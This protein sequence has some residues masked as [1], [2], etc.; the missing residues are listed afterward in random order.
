MRAPLPAGGKIELG[1]GYAGALAPKASPRRRL[2]RASRGGG[3]GWG[4]ASRQQQPTSIPRTSHHFATASAAK[5]KKQK[6]RQSAWQARGE[7]SELEVSGRA[8]GAA[9]R[10]PPRRGPWQGPGPPGGPA[11]VRCTGQSCLSAPARTFKPRK[12]NDESSRKTNAQAASHLWSPSNSMAQAVATVDLNWRPQALSQL[13]NFR[14]Q[15]SMRSCRPACEDD[16]K[17][18]EHS[19]EHSR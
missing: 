4:G 11:S 7:V 6:A 3:G 12:S 16:G 1:T 15:G 5:S 2:P 18:L 17:R 19:Q 10:P 8:W 9:P 13:R 14:A